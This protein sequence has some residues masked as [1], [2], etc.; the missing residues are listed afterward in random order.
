[1]DADWPADWGSGPTNQNV[2]RS[3]G[4]SERDVPPP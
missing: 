3:M 2:Q 1:M 4:S